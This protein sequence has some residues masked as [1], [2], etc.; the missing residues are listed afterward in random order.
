MFFPSYN[1][2][3]FTINS[4]NTAGNP[5]NVTKPIDKALIGNNKPDEFVIKF[6]EYKT[7]N[8]IT[9]FFTNANNFFI[10]ILPL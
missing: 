5:K 1:I 3:N 10:Y 8:A 7:I 6:T 2:N 4:A 9:I